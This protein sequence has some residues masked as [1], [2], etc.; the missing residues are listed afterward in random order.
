[1]KLTDAVFHFD[2]GRVLIDRKLHRGWAKFFG[3]KRNVWEKEHLVLLGQLASKF[4]VSHDV[5]AEELSKVEGFDDFMLVIELKLAADE[6]YQKLK[7]EL[8]PGL[9]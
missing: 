6:G 1:M 8:L 9:H 3:F 2:K 4:D 7:A 5:L